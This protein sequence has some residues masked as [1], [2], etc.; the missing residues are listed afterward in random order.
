MKKIL[1]MTDFSVNAAHAADYAFRL[2]SCLQMDILLYHYTGRELPELA[3]EQGKWPEERWLAQQRDCVEQL[4]VL[5]IATRKLAETL[6]TGAYLPSVQYEW[7][8]GTFDPRLRQYHSKDSIELLVA[9]P[10]D[11]PSEGLITEDHAGELIH[12]T[13]LPLLIVPPGADFQ[14]FKKIVFA[15]TFSEYELS[16]MGSVVKLAKRFQA[17]LVLAPITSPGKEHKLCTESCLAT[18]KDRTAYKNIR[19]QEHWQGSVPPLDKISQQAP[20]DLLVIVHREQ[21]PQNPTEALAM[22]HIAP[23]LVLY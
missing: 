4:R 16:L 17:E 23:L 2:A 10:H 3:G 8:D 13:L 5:S 20:Y 6:T 9:G 1:V 7:Y 15:T 22:G 21:T 18:I 19:Y 12:A 14:P 11:R